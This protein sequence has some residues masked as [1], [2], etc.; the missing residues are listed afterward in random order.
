MPIEEM[1]TRIEV[2]LSEDDRIGRRTLP[3]L[4]V[5]RARESGMA[6][7]TIWK[8]VEGFGSSGRM[9]TDRFPDAGTGLPMVVELIDERHRIE[10]F[11]VTV[12]ELAPD[13]LVTREP[14]HVVRH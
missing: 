7:A 10:A 9:R 13:A 1:R 14:V 12:R 11:L 8:G 5:D 6:G 2:F 3:E 4:I